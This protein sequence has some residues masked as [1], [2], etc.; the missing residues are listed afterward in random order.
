MQ[1]YGVSRSGGARTRL[2]KTANPGDT[3]ILVEPGL[4]WQVNDTIGLA[5]TAM[6]WQ[7]SDYAVVKSYDNSTGAVTLDRKLDY[8]HWGASVSTAANYSGVDMRGEVILL[9][10]NIRIVGNDSEAWGC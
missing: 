3:Q 6:I 5:P 10:R 8:Y 2:L 7:E 1:M 4:G 9:N